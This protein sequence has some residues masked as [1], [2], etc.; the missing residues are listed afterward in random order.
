MQWS[1][2]QSGNS[3]K[4]L[5]NTTSNYHASSANCAQLLCIYP[6]SIELTFYVA[7]NRK[8]RSGMNK[9][10]IVTLL[11]QYQAA[12]FVCLFAIQNIFFT[13]FI[14]HSPDWRF[15]STDTFLLT[16]TLEYHFFQK[17]TFVSSANLTQFSRN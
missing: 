13:R 17:V 7:E 15:I 6:I 2:K 11:F 14:Y 16:S 9:T 3:S 10:T 5:F 1:T 8:C 4:T 12:A